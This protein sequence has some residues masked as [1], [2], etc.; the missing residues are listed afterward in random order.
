VQADPL[1]LPWSNRVREELPGVGL[2][3]AH[4]H[5]GSNDPDG[6]SSTAEELLEGLEF[7]DA[8]A[9]V[10]TMHEPEGY[11]Q[12]NDRVI[13]EAEA[14]GGRLVAFARL[15]PR[16]DPVGEAERCLDRGAR[17]IKLHPRAERFNL[18]EPEVE[19]IFAL[20]HERRVPVLCHAGRGI[21]ALGRDALVYTERYPNMRLILAHAG[22]CDLGW[23]WREAP[24]HPNLFFD[25]AWWSAADLL[26]LFTLI[27]PG[28]ILWASDAPYGTPLG[29]VL[30]GLRA[31]LQAGLGGEQ[32][33][34]VAGEQ[35]ERLV[36]GEEPLDVGPAPGTGALRPDPLLDR[37]VTFLT[38]AIARLLTG[39]DAEEPLSLARLACDVPPDVPEAPV[40]AS[41]L[42]MLDLRDRAMASETPLPRSG[43]GPVVYA[44]SLAAT[45][46]VALPATEEIEELLAA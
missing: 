35:V 44:Q 37:V 31:G 3:D 19:P 27:P 17:G 11:S 34:S 36:A 28:Q 6:M 30:I 41:V 14:S 1:I 8:R 26:A 20:A 2:V 16:Q 9:V 21:P 18:H 42:A 7:A 39:S 23:I 25:T 13:A 29:A 46:D 22:I 5:T 45:P 38:A 10:F 32:M 43:V 4:T 33:R 40:C 15:D 12:A 24:R